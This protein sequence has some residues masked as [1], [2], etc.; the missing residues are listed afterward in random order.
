MY[1]KWKAVLFWLKQHIGADTPLTLRT[2]NTYTYVKRRYLTKWQHRCNRSGQSKKWMKPWCFT[3][4]FSIFRHSFL[5]SHPR[6]S[7]FSGDHR[8]LAFIMLLLPCLYCMLLLRISILIALCIGSNLCGNYGQGQ[9]NNILCEEPS[10]ILYC[11][12]SCEILQQY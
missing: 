4:A 3:F 6:N 2:R 1:S 12:Q 9:C 7:M 8:I 10:V 5:F 11:Y